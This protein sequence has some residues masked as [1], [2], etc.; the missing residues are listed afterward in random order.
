M[1]RSQKCSRRAVFAAQQHLRHEAV[2]DHVGRAP[3]AGDHGVVA[4]VPPEVVGELLRPT[5]DLPAAEHVEALVIDQE[6]AA[7]RLAL[8]VAERLDIDPLG[9]AMHGVRPAVA[10]ASASSSGSMIF[11]ICGFRDRAWCR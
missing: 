10:G 6:N 9:T 7:R 11:T 4:E 2:L 5:V 3:F 8:G 1:C